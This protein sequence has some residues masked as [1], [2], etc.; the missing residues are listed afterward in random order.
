MLVLGVNDWSLY[1]DFDGR[2][3]LILVEV[4]QDRLVL[5]ADEG[6]KDGPLDASVG[7]PVE[8]QVRLLDGTLFRTLDRISLETLYE[9]L[10]G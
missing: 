2:D 9:I 7:I 10:D 8:V 4:T 6:V 5:N 1:E 3:V